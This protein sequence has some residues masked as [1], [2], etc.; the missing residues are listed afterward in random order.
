MAVTQEL[1]VDCPGGCWSSDELAALW[2]AVTRAADTE[3]P[4]DS[5]TL[6]TDAVEQVCNLIENH[7]IS[8]VLKNNQ[9]PETVDAMDAEVVTDSLRSS[10]PHMMHHSKSQKS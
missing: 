5:S 1:N 9:P 6:S 8:E 4:Q 3:D 7:L 10:L 2:R